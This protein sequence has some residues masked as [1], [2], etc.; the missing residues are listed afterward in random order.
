MRIA[1]LS[2][3]P[4]WFSGPLGESV[5]GRARERGLIQ[6]DLINIRDFATDRHRSVDDAPYGGGGGQVLRA[7]VLARAL[8]ESVGAPGTEGRPRVLMMSPR[9]TPFD[10]AMAL[11]L[12]RL[13]A[14]ALVCGH[15]EAVDQRLIDTRIDEEVSLGDF[16]LTGGEIPAM[17][18]VDALARHVPGVLGN[19]TSAERDSFMNGL[20]EGPHFTRPEVFEDRGVPPV[21]MG[22]NHAAIEEW[23]EG[24]SLRLTRERR[25]EL[26]AAQILHPE[27]VRRL[28]RRAR[29][30]AVWRAQPGGTPEPIYLSGAVA[31]RPDWRELLGETRWEKGLS[32]GVRLA[33]IRE[34]RTDDTDADAARVREEISAAAQSVGAT[35]LIGNLKRALDDHSSS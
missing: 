12:A 2:L 7:D 27:Q 3:F 35:T 11:R 33:E 31:E 21:L 25:P 34:A 6:L 16:V 32:P 13:P 10:Q 22:G 30:F 28:A 20:L 24:E 15:Y 4:G 1:I 9:G 8:D 17:A 23:R 14:V 5:I 18:I 26:Y 19:E 29:P